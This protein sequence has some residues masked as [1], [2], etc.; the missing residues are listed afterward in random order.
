MSKHI[1]PWLERPRNSVNIEKLMLRIACACIK[2]RGDLYHLG[3]WC[4]T[5]RKTMKLPTWAPDFTSGICELAV[6]YASEGT[7]RLI[8]GSYNICGELL[9]LDCHLLDSI[10]WSHSIEDCS[11]LESIIEIVRGVERI[12]GERGEYGLFQEYIVSREG[13]ASRKSFQV[14][15]QELLQQLSQAEQI[16]RKSTC[17]PASCLEQLRLV[18]DSVQRQSAA[19]FQSSQLIIEA[20]WLLLNPSSPTRKRSTCLGEHLFLAWLYLASM[21]AHKD[22]QI[23]C[24]NL[25][26]AYGGLIYALMPTVMSGMERSDKDKVVEWTTKFTHEHLIQTKISQPEKECIFVTKR[27]L[28]GRTA[29]GE[30]HKGDVVSFLEGGWVPNILQRH[31]QFYSIKSFAYIEGLT[32]IK[33]KPA[34]WEIERICLR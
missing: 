31:E 25:P 12:I 24:A 34:N 17:C 3:Q 5:S 28:F 14:S 33:M 26:K 18:H 29:A 15:R 1:I 7:S 4:V 32:E 8:Q 9:C 21:E 23:D 20:L 2:E 6:K 22:F 19:A 16:L 11:D 10:E 27:R 13:W 30:A